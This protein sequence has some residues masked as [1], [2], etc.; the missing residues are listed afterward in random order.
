MITMTKSS[1]LEDRKK[2]ERIQNH[3]WNEI[4]SV[5]HISLPRLKSAVRKEFK[6]KDDR[7]VRTQIELM[8]TEARIRIESRV[9]VW[10]RPP[11]TCTSQSEHAH[12]SIG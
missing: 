10:I 2:R 11:R 4:G 7:Y 1:E 3:F 12:S 8:Q 6:C 9:K 5:E